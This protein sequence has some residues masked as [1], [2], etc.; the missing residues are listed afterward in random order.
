MDN[1]LLNIVKIVVL[2]GSI[3][4][5]LLSAFGILLAIIW[6]SSPEYN[7]ADK[8]VCLYFS[9]SI[10]VAVS[11]VIKLIWRGNE[12]ILPIIS[13]IV[14]LLLLFSEIYL[15]VNTGFSRPYIAIYFLVPILLLTLFSYDIYMF[16]IKK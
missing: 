16:L 7:Y 5:S 9:T 11:L 6:T 12:I 10:I 13:V 15:R 14:G 2:V 3:V 4:T 1:K 8:L